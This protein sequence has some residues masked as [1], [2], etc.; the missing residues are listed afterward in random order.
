MF[1]NLMDL[2]FQR[3]VKQAFGFYIAYLFLIMLVGAL[4]AGRYALVTGNSGFEVGAKVGNI[5]AVVFV[6]G[7][8]ST[9]VSQKKMLNFTVLLSVVFSGVLA[10]FLGGLGGLIPAAYLSTKAEK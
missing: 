7:I 2:K 10:L 8:T 1:S 3:S 4:L 9:I 6:L 5:V